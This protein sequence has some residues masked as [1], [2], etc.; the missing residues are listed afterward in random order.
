MLENEE[1]LVSPE[2]NPEV[3][4]LYEVLEHALERIKDRFRLVIEKR[5]Y[6]REQVVILERVLSEL[7]S[8][9]TTTDGTKIECMRNL[10]KFLRAFLEE[11]WS[12]YEMVDLMEHV[13]K[14]QFKAVFVFSEQM[15]KNYEE[16]KTRL[17]ERI[18]TLESDCQKIRSEK[19][20]LETQNNLLKNMLKQRNDEISRTKKLVDTIRTERDE[21]MLHLD[22]VPRCAI[23][24]DKQPTV[25][26]QPCCHCVCCES[27][28]KDLLQCPMCRQDIWKKITV[29][30]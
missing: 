20:N 10:L 29:Y 4:S 8:E 15:K 24:L 19:W 3:N 26:Y 17:N 11:K 12:N 14:V 18:E 22:K 27:C 16:E 5:D 30:R 28:G 21:M 1:N 2:F 6:F 9:Q 13:I 23:C 25:L 7:E